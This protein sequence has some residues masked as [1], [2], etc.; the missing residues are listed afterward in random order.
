MSL[1]FAGSALS[2]NIFH[3][4]TI[5]IST[6]DAQSESNLLRRLSINIRQP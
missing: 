2:V 6:V 1:I 3:K 4:I 5:L